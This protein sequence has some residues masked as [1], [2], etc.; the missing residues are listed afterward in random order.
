MIE[1]VL[2]KVG[3][4]IFLVDFFILEIEPVAN[5]KSHISVILGRPFLT[6]ANAEINC[7]NELMKLSFGNMTIELNI[8]NLKQESTQYADV[9][10]IQNKIYEPIDI[11][12]E[13]VDLESS[14]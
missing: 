13:E 14:F 6:I 1:D 11:S 3:N 8:F 5:F 9:N 10:I 4:F 2:I 12:D 7:R